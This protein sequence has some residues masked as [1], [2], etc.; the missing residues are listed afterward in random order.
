M[1][2]LRLA[3]SVLLV[4]VVSLCAHAC[5]GP[6]LRPTVVCD[7]DARATAVSESIGVS[8]MQCGSVDVVILD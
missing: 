8:R 7:D 1:L 3:L 5:N 2:L 6:V 4:S